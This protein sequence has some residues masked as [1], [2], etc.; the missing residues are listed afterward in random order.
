MFEN[1]SALS[2]DTNTWGQQSLAKSES[3][4][5]SLDTPINKSSAPQSQADPL[6]PT[7]PLPTLPV[8]SANPNPN[9]YLTSAALVPDFNGDGKADKLWVN[10]QTGE[11]LVRLMNVSFTPG[12]TIISA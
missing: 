7:N 9:P 6:F 4:R 12:F 2:L 3:L 5:T 8:G 11:I 10:A 1:K